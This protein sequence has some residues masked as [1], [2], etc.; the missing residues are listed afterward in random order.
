[1]SE[2]EVLCYIVGS[3]VSLS[4]DCMECFFILFALSLFA[5]SWLPQ[6]S[7]QANF[8]FDL[9]KDERGWVT[10]MWR[11]DEDNF[12]PSMRMYVG[13]DGRQFS[14]LGEIRDQSDCGDQR[15]L[16]SLY[17]LSYLKFNPPSSI[18][19]FYYGHRHMPFQ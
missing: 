2:P 14:R 5:V 11:G 4:A 13:G 16:Q 12:D 7:S 6:V 18:V 17:Y 19:V 10:D 9:A 15:W 3:G 8:I 1:M